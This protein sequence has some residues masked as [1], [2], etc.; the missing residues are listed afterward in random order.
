MAS[1]IHRQETIAGL[2]RFNARRKLKG[3]FI[4][5]LIAVRTQNAVGFGMFS[6]DYIV[7]MIGFHSN[8]S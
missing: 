5:S 3:A 8:T 7:A 1:T 2:K 4:T 6:L